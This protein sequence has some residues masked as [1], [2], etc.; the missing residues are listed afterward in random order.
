[1]QFD[2]VTALVG[3]WLDKMEDKNLRKEINALRTRARGAEALAEI[4][5]DANVIA[6]LRAYAADLEA[7]VAALEHGYQVSEGS[8]PSM[9]VSPEGASEAPVTDAGGTSKTEP[10]TTIRTEPHRIRRVNLLADGDGRETISPYRRLA[11]QANRNAELA[12]DVHRWYVAMNKTMSAL[13]DALEEHE[14]PT[15]K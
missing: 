15:P 14:K 1:V 6:N 8:L 3:V 4:A 2:S 9:S 10:A 13:A 5:I 12:E 11:S 7:K